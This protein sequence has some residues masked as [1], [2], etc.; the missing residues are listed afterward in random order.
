METISIDHSNLNTYLYYNIFVHFTKYHIWILLG[1]IFLLHNILRFNKN[2]TKYFL[3]HFLFNMYI[4]YNTLNHT[5][6]ILYNPYNIQLVNNYISFC[7]VVFHIY[8]IIFYYKD[9]KSD[10]LIHH[11]WMVFIIL[12]ITWLSY[13]NLAD[14]SLFFMT[15][16]P[17]GITY[18]LLVL[19]DMKLISSLTEK[20]I[21]KQLNTFIRIPGSVIVGYIIF[22]NAITTETYLFQ[23]LLIFCSIGSLWNGIYFGSAIISSYA[24]AEER[25]YRDHEF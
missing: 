6:E 1:T 19:K 15:G 13:Y 18:L 23:Y 11:I 3:M 9:I 16:L 2:I 5:L 4:S 24:I 25:L 12:P 14:A 22:I 8:H 10:E 17:G 7:V 20:Y 21:S